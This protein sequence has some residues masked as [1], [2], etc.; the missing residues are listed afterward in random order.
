MLVSHTLRTWTLGL[1]KLFTPIRESNIVIIAEE[2]RGAQWG[3]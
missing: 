1:G 3:K 2:T